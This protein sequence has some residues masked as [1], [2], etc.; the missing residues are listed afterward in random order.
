MKASLE[1]ISSTGSSSLGDGRNL[2][3]SEPI[4]MT[5]DDTSQ[6]DSTCE[7]KSCTSGPNEELKSSKSETVDSKMKA[8]T[9]DGGSKKFR[10]YGAGVGTF[11]T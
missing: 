7:D 11:L 3:D 9:T 5:E 4:K 6:K 1:A 8:A 10:Y 2:K